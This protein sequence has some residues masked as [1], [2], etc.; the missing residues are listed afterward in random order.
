MEA[1]YFVCEK[2][3]LE[4]ARHPKETLLV[5][6]KNLSDGF[7]WVRINA[8]EV[9]VGDLVSLPCLQEGVLVHHGL[10]A[11]GVLIVRAVVKSI[12]SLSSDG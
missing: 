7:R 4:F 6:R 11:E 1:L 3:D 12:T 10:V 2:P 5:T 8:D 9:K